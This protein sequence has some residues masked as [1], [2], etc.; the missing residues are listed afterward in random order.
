MK[1]ITITGGCGFIGRNLTKALLGRGDRVRILDNLSVGTETELAGVAPVRRGPEWPEDPAT[2]GLIVGDIRDPAAC[3]SALAGTQAAVHLAA[4]SGV[5]PSIEAPMVDCQTNVIGTLNMLQACV[6]R[7]TGQFVFASSSAPLGETTPPVHE[8][9]PARPMSPYG[10]SK[11]AGE[12]YCSAY[13]HSFGIRTTALRFSNVYGPGS[14]HKGSVVAWFFR[15]ALEG[16]PL[17]IYGDGEQTRDF[18][19]IDD[20]CSAILGALDSDTGG[21][22]FQIA[23]FHESTVNEIAEHIQRLVERDRG[24]R[25]HIHRTDARKG[26][27]IRSFSDISKAR[28]RIGYEPRVSLEEGL[29]RTWIW[30]RENYQVGAKT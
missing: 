27:I 8:G 4:Q 1:S 11:L 26:E 2:V 13:F 22:T 16:R 28:S 9:L 5:M 6:E 23:T 3:A 21:E 10:A 18:I 12:G 20:L 30:F 14:A 15:C 19:Y 29:E 17:T 25:V 24:T 7:G